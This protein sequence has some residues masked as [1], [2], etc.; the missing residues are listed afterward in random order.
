MKIL[1]ARRRQAAL[2]GEAQGNRWEPGSSAAMP[3]TD[4]PK[5]CGV[6]M[7]LRNMEF[8]TSRP[9]WKSSQDLHLGSRTEEWERDDYILL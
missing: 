6:H 3:K 5:D 9:S 2:R 7:L 1:P 4:D 8:N